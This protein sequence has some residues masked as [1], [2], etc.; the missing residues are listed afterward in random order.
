MDVLREIEDKESFQEDLR[1]SIDSL[2]KGH[3]ERERK[4][5][6]LF[7]L[8]DEIRVIAENAYRGR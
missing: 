4:I 2:P 7:V 1:K 3:P 5:D 8:H 6:L